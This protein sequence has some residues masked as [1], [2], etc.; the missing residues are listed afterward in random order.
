MTSVR[1]ILISY[2][3]WD[4]IIYLSNMYEITTS[5]L[6]LLDNKLIKK[7][8]MI[9][10]W[11]DIWMMCCMRIVVSIN[12]FLY[13]LF[14]NHSRKSSH[15]YAHLIT[16]QTPMNIR[17]TKSN[18]TLQFRKSI[19]NEIIRLQLFTTHCFSTFR[20]H[21]KAHFITHVLKIILEICWLMQFSFV[22]CMPFFEFV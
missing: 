19:N 7:I 17:Y 16:F 10:L 8:A 20:I 2:L 11:F 13:L 14:K 12:M 21:A 18:H 22:L 9:G 5:L 1:S 4:A 6:K 3:Y 15:K